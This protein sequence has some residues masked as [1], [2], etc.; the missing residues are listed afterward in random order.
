MHISNA[1]II[2]N[3]RGLHN[4]EMLCAHLANSHRTYY[5]DVF[6]PV[7]DYG[8]VEN[9]INFGLPGSTTN[10]AIS[11]DELYVYEVITNYKIKEIYL[12]SM[13][14]TIR[15]ISGNS[16]NISTGVIAVSNTIIAIVAGTAVCEINRS[17]WVC[18]QRVVA[19][20]LNSVTC[21]VFSNNDTILNVGGTD[22]PF[23]RRINTSTWTL[24]SNF[25]TTPA[26]R[27]IQMSL[28]PDG[29]KLA[30]AQQLNT[31]QLLILDTITRAQ[32]SSPSIGTRIVSSVAYNL[33]GSK[34]AVGLSATPYVIVYNTSNWS[35]DTTYAASSFISI[36]VNALK[37]LNTSNHIVCL[38][39]TNSTLPIVLTRGG[40]YQTNDNW[41]HADGPAK[42]EVSPSRSLFFYKSISLEANGVQY[43][44]NYT[45][46]QY[47]R[48]LPK[49]YSKLPSNNP[50]VGVTISRRINVL[51]RYGTANAGYLRLFNLV[52]GDELAQP[53]VLPTSNVNKAVF[54]PDGRRLVVRMESTPFIIIYN[55]S[56]WTQIPNPAT[57]PNG[58]GDAIYSPNGSFLVTSF[59][60]APY[61]RIYNT[62]N[63]TTVSFTTIPGASQSITF[64]PNG[65]WMAVSHGSTP[66]VTRYNVSG[67]EKLGDPSV[68]PEGV[69]SQMVFTGN[70]DRLIMNMQSRIPTLKV[71]NT[72]NWTLNTTSD[73]LF[74]D[75]SISNWLQYIAI[76]SVGTQLAVTRPG[77]GQGPWYVYNLS[78][79]TYVT[80]NGQANIKINQPSEIVVNQLAYL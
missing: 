49:Y 5:S 42:I 30:I 32:A 46:N 17:T 7:N 26:V 13:A 27:V 34:L 74:F 69:A 1:S 20:S 53:S 52:S 47:Q 2:N 79:W 48:V 18:T 60:S 9:S 36:G 38:R 57:I 65:T 35:E 21:A 39:A 37:F 41:L 72:S 23:I 43:I 59:T 8:L 70:S 4:T 14:V 33:D 54:S 76:N 68:I 25:S 61:L 12:P 10:F 51:V 66:F 11:P 50:F 71:Y 62:S 77:T 22:S 64:S 16:I 3:R 73:S 15:N 24:A 80:I 45:S 55:T 67:W 63:W 28:S 40:S 19:G 78:D 44:A 58:R 31:P 29:T 75:N 6:F 56:N